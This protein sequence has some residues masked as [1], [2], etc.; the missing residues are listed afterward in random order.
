GLFLAVV[1]AVVSS[2]FAFPEVNRLLFPL[3]EAS[4]LISIGTFIQHM[5]GGFVFLW[6][7]V[8]AIYLAVA[9][10][11]ISYIWQFIWQIRVHRPILPAIALLVFTGAIIPGDILQI[12]QWARFLYSGWSTLAIFVIPLVMVNVAGILH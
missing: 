8:Q 1:Q 3:M 9:L 6:F 2:L 7:F 11:M 10:Y 5:E 4:R 12:L